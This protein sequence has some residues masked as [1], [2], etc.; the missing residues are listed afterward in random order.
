MN[1][2]LWGLLTNLSGSGSGRFKYRSRPGGVDR[3]RCSP[4]LRIPRSA[5]WGDRGDGGRPLSTANF[6]RSFERMAVPQS[7]DRAG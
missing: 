5:N 7:V 3:W 1:R 6:S 4:Q 2:V